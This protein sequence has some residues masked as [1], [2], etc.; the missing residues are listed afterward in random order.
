M[1][2]VLRLIQQ[3]QS[4]KR[5]QFIDLEKQF[6]QLEHRGILPHGQRM[7]PISSREPG[8]TLIWEGQFPDVGAA[9][10]ALKLFE[11]SPEHTEHGTVREASAVF[12]GHLG[13]TL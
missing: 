7:T 9:E 1:A 6:A 13:R 3:F 5:Q 8:N 10:K 12:P 4:P 11:T 2:I